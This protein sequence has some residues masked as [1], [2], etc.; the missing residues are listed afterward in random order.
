MTLYIYHMALRVTYQ[1]ISP[2]VTRKLWRVML[3]DAEGR[4]QHFALGLSCHRGAAFL[5]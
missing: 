4:G 1:N 5:V 2:E 3:P